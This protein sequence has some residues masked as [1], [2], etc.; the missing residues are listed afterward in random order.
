MQARLDR[1]KCDYGTCSFDNVYQPKPIEPSLKFIAMSAWYS[2]FNNLAPNVSLAPNQDG[3]YDLN[4]TNLATIRSAIHA[5]CNQS[6]SEIPNPDRFRPRKTQSAPMWLPF[7]SLLFLVLCF[8][9]MYHWTLLED[10]YGMNDENLKN[11]HIV[12]TINKNDIGWAMGYMINQTNYLEAEYRPAR[13]LTK[14]EFAGLLSLCSIVLL[15][16]VIMGIVSIY[17]FKRYRHY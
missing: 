15:A 7:A 11:F 1:S 5:I 8:N 4:T 12:K 14:S 2:T 17:C 3:N 6:W 13:L 10:G 9:S 16:S